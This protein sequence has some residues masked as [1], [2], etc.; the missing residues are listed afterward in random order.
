[1]GAA[2]GVVFAATSTG[3]AAAGFATADLAGGVT[4]GATRLV[5][6]F[7]D[8]GTLATTALLNY[9][10]VHHIPQRIRISSVLLHCNIMVVPALLH[11]RQT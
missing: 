8:V 2:T 10:A 6:G 3:C 11:M 9:V 4:A 5:T 7:V 1:L